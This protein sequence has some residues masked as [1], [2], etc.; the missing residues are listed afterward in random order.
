MARKKIRPIFLA[1]ALLALPLAGCGSDY[2]L[3]AEQEAAAQHGSNL[4]GTLSGA[5]SSAQN[6]AM[7][8][9]R[10]EFALLNPKV[11]MQ[12]SPDGSGAGRT[13]FLAGAVDFAGSDAYLDD[14]EMELAKDVCG[15]G[16]AY[17]VP[18]YVSPI[19]VG[20][21]L[22]GITELNLDAATI[23]QIFKGEIA[24]WSDP[25][26]ARQNPGVDLPDLPVSPV[27]RGDDSGT[28]ENFTEYLHAVAPKAWTADPSDSF[29]AEYV[30]ENAQGNAGVV[31]M[32]ARTKG[33]VTYADDSAVGPPLGKV[34]LKV[35]DDYVPV[36]A[37]AAAKALDQSKPVE[38]R[39][40]GDLALEL[41]RTTTAAGAYPLLLVSYHVYCSSYEDAHR[42][43]LA[44]TFAKY[45]LSQEGQAAAA[46]SAKSAPLSERL[47]A[48][49]IE[50]VD[51]ISVR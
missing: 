10:A 14:E 23:A 45:V 3:G 13:A 12:Y 39:P 21:N 28:T 41:N 29:P 26:I 16:G 46:E 22:P 31:S 24:T 20:F 2:P 51:R 7:D 11:Q 44:K 8:A 4:E 32:V 48:Q 35:G 1:A 9:W 38:G 36:T 33:A 15:P 47:S 34:N 19:A 50:T 37:E 18:A 40:E 30:G 49:A 17:N 43:E 25:A 5:G 27:T 6:A 42:V